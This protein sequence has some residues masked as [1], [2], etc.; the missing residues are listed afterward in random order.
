METLSLSAANIDHAVFGARA[1]AVNGSSVFAD[2]FTFG[3]ATVPEPATLL[4]AG[5][6]LLAFLV[7]RRRRTL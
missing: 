2:N 3:E 7:A 6:G 5:L 1:P 4:P